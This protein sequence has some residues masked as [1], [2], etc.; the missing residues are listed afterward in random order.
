MGFGDGR[1]RAATLGAAAL[2]AQQVVGK[3][4][5]DALFLTSFGVELLPYAMLCAAILSGG[6]LMG[7]ARAVRVRSARGVART[8]LL[9]S[10]AL[11]VA[12]WLVS[13]ASPQGAAALTYLHSGVLSAASAS[14][15]WALVSETFDPYAARGSVPRVMAGGALG[16]VVGGLATWQAATM[17]HPHE[18]LPLAAALN[19]GCVAAVPRLGGEAARAAPTTGG[20]WRAL[21][22]GLP[23]LRSVALLV[24]CGALTQALLEYLL[25][26]AAVSSLGKGPRL[27][28]FFALFQTAVG[29]LSFALQLAVSRSVLERF[30][31]GVVLSVSPVLLFAGVVAVSAA[32][33]LL[34]A[35]VLRGTDGVLGASLHRSAYEVL[36]APLD[37][38][39]RRASKP[40]LDVGVDRL[41]MLLGSGFVAAIAATVPRGSARAVL[42]AAVAVLALVRLLLSPLL[43]AGYRH[44]L[45]DQLRDGTLALRDTDVLDRNTARSL[46][47]AASAL[48]RP[49]LLAEVARFRER[50]A[51]APARDGARVAVAA[52]ETDNTL[53][54]GRSTPIT[55][56]PAVTVRSSGRRTRRST[57]S[58]TSAAAKPTATRIAHIPGRTHIAFS[59]VRAMASVI[60][61]PAITLGANCCTAS[62]VVE[63]MQC[64]AAWR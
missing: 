60:K 29:V 7:L 27:L 28:P 5:R 45:A 54:V 44:T 53:A 58:H 17:L 3:A 1:V 51:R 34:A 55:G 57:A 62:H 52:F 40:L 36:F 19:L 31:V 56:T 42:L 16:G 10:A 48:D 6:L 41:G 11:L 64:V 32:S 50:Q 47:R 4:L 2:V 59:A 61:A 37:S 14:V 13:G 15:F 8:A 18:L 49:A 25:S 33:P 26:S 63:R 23:Y 35:V 9:G 30:G 12:A 22:R 38:A 21:E 46:S 43:Q 24:L 20:G 39:R